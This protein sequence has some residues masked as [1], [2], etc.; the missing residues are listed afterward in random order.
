MIPTA[1]LRLTFLLLA[2]CLSTTLGQDC[3]PVTGSSVCRW[4]S[5]AQVRPSFASSVFQFDYFAM[6]YASYASLDNLYCNFNM[7]SLRYTTANVCNLML[8]LP[9][10]VGGCP[11]TNPSR[12][13]QRL[14]WYQCDA[15]LKTFET[16]LN[17]QSICTPTF[18][19]A[20]IQRRQ[21]AL[22]LY[23]RQCRDRDFVD[24]DITN[25]APFCIESNSENCGFTT[26]SAMREYC[27]DGINRRFDRCCHTALSRQAT[28]FPRPTIPIPSP[29]G[30]DPG[31]PPSAP[32][33]P[34][35]PVPDPGSPST[36]NGPAPAPGSPSTPNGPLP[37]PG[38]PS[39]PN[40]PAPIPQ[41]P[42]I[43]GLPN[44]S[45]RVATPPISNQGN[46]N[47]PLNFPSTFPSTGND[48]SNQVSPRADHTQATNTPALDQSDS[49]WCKVIGSNCESALGLIFGGV[50]VVS[51][52]ITGLAMFVH[53]S[54]AQRRNALQNSQKTANQHFSLPPLA[55]LPVPEQPAQTKTMYG[56]FTRNPKLD[57]A[58]PPPPSPAADEPVE[59]DLHKIDVELPEVFGV[60]VPSAALLKIYRR[61]YLEFVPVGQIKRSIRWIKSMTSVSSFESF[62]NSVYDNSDAVSLPG[63]VYS[64]DSLSPSESPSNGPLRR[65]HDL[66]FS[67]GSI[68]S[69]HISGHRNEYVTSKPN[70][71]IADRS[72][73]DV[74][75]STILVSLPEVLLPKD[76][77]PIA[78]AAAESHTFASP[79]AAAIAE[80]GSSIEST[81]DQAGHLPP[82]LPATSDFGGVK[83]HEPHVDGL[84]QLPL[85]PHVQ[86][87]LDQ[88]H[89]IYQCILPLTYTD[90]QNLELN[91]G[92][93]LVVYETLV[94]GYAY[95]ENLSTGVH[96]RFSLANINILTT[97][98]P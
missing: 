34:S 83:L 7:E 10:S 43:P 72:L 26:I 37:D 6:T 76:S 68:P 67:R 97:A 75:A 30:P 60:N 90:D 54:A 64:S 42:P 25:Y 33:D 16:Q 44:P 48:N 63:S 59:Q 74:R 9:E 24:Q 69:R 92:D 18:D 94:D 88:G 73:Q 15:F 98:N 71:S 86:E 57:I 50:V 20:L 19:F 35:A 79:I 52:F 62:R 56:L 14:C 1:F 5:G 87:K 47:I 66:D 13:S 45:G 21:N 51:I 8:H 81:D 36:P 84:Q 96:G 61:N 23:R 80:C 49:S 3:V 85:E 40:G 11:N 4:W 70:I 77:S 91:L 46:P 55:A 38:S 29:N 27:S 95:G 32:N 17:D 31:T 58:P 82:L 28:I 65:S 22:H 53:N 41:S 78:T 12:S 89:T 2:G 39:T 93:R